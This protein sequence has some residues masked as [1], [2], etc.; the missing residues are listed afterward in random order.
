MGKLYRENFGH[1]EDFCE[2]KERRRL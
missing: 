1:K 2:N